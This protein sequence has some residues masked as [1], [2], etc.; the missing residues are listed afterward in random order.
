MNNKQNKTIN[1]RRILVDDNNE[2]TIVKKDKGLILEWKV[3]IFSR[4]F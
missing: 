3:K 2:N 4:V 1:I